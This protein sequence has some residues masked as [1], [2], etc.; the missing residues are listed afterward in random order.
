MYFIVIVAGYKTLEVI[1]GHANVYLH[2]SKIKKWDL[3]APNGLLNALGGR[4]TTLQGTH[5]TYGGTDAHLDV[6]NYGGVVAALS[7]HQKFV[8]VFGA[9]EK[10]N[11]VPRELRSVP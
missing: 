2:T 10:E 6:V 8:D 7:E 4:L 5:L 9:L 1:K 3:C 11:K